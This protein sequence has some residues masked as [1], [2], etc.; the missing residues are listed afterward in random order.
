MLHL[1]TVLVRITGETT[2]V[3]KQVVSKTESQAINAI[4]DSIPESLENPQDYFFEAVY[5]IPIFEGL[6]L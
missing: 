4:A 1:F 5:S 3:L 2:P 6:V